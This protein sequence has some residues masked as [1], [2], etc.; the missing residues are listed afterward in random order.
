VTKSF[1]DARSYN[2]FFGLAQRMIAR[3][4][5]SGF[6]YFSCG[7]EVFWG[8]DVVETDASRVGSF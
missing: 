5:F 2:E 6:G 3:G 4:E 7:V 8:V 1:D